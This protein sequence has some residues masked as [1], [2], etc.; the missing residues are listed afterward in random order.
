MAALVDDDERALIAA[1]LAFVQAT[2]ADLSTVETLRECLRTGRWSRSM[3][4]TAR[5]LIA[6]Q[7]SRC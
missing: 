3:L 5:R 7:G 2:H 4:D 1:W 6:E